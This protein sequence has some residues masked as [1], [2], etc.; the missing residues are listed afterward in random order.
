M[1]S[2]RKAT[3]DDVERYY[4]WANDDEVRKNSYQTQA[5]SHANHVQWFTTK[6]AS[7]STQLLIFENENKNA[8][9]QVRIETDKDKALIGISIDAHHRGK[10]YAVQLI[11]LASAQYFKSY[12]NNFIIAYIKKDNFTSYKAFVAAGYKLLEELTEAGVPSYKMILKNVSI[13]E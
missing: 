1:L 5:I 13:S 7:K 2:Y 11:K 12:P 6:L 8:V 4:Q 10:G 9:G 3:I